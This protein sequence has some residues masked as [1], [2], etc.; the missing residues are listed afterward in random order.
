MREEEQRRHTAASKVQAMHRGN[1]ARLKVRE[2]EGER[3]RREEEARSAEEALKAKAE[4][5]APR[6]SRQRKVGGAPSS[7]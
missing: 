5:E 6:S 7:S 1:M 2:M 4:E 3:A